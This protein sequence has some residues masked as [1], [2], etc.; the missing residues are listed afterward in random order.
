MKKM[1]KGGKKSNGPK[2]GSTTGTNVGGIRTPFTG[3]MTMGKGR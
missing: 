2:L 3:R 1:Y